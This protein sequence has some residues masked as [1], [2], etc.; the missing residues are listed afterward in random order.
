M[1]CKSMPKT[2]AEKAANRRYNERNPEKVKEWQKRAD[3]KRRRDAKWKRD[4][5]AYL[6]EY[7]LRRKLE[8]RPVPGGAVYK[9]RETEN[10]DNP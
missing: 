8:G 7:R 6:R 5:A 4:R 9:K 1:S 2:E 10:T 3:A